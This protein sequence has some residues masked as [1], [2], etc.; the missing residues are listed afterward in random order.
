MGKMEDKNN[1]MESLRSQV[2]CLHLLSF[3]TE[4]KLLGNTNATC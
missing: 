1:A 3:N 2:K 4:A